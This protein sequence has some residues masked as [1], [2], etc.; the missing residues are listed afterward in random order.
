MFFIVL[1]FIPKRVVL[2]DNQILVYRFCF[3]LQITFWD[4]SGFNDR[5][6][7]SQII[8]C[9]KQDSEIRFGARKP[10]FYVNN[11]S[12]VEIRTA[13]KVYLLPIKNSD[14]FIVE[15]NKRIGT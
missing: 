10:F 8:S 15:V 14:N 1:I 13:H 12:I 6:N 7:Y 9:K 5:I 11:D 4:F 3:P 2:T